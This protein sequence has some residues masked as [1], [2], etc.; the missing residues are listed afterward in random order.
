[1]VRPA[2]AL[3][4]IACVPERHA[5]VGGACDALHEC[6]DNLA[7]QGGVC[8]DDHGGAGGGG[9]GG[10]AGGAAGCTGNLMGDGD[11]EEGPSLAPVYWS[12]PGTVQGGTVHG[13]S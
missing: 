1:M 4:L 13:G 10:A 12:V 8:V 7:C 3:L 5:V 11:F 2:L 6:P 9:G